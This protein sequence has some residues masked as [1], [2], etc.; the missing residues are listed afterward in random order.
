M[1]FIINKY[2]KYKAR[3][4]FY[5]NRIDSWFARISQGLARDKTSTTDN[6][7]D[8]RYAVRKV[9]QYFYAGNILFR[10]LKINSYY[11]FSSFE[12]KTKG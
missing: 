9:N 10:N 7:E 8:I 6:K 11:F 1:I 5:F 4:Y 12:R 2:T 3:I